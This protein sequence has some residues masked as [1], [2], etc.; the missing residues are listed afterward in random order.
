MVHITLGQI[1]GT[2][3]AYP[4]R[5]DIIKRLGDSFNKTRLTPTAEQ[6]MQSLLASRGQNRSDAADA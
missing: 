3:H 1:S 2:I 4:T 6:F 5:M